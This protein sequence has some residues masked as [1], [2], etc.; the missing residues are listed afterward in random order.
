MFDPTQ[1]TGLIEPVLRNLNLSGDY[2]S[3]IMVAAGLMLSGI[4]APLIFS[5]LRLAISISVETIRVPIRWTRGISNELAIAIYRHG[6]LFSRQLARPLALALLVGVGYLVVAASF[7]GKASS[8][9]AKQTATTAATCSGEIV[10]L[11]C[12]RPR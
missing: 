7:G 3:Y 2:S 6:P 8:Q 9:A 1:L 10:D 4:F 12:P 11:S 5:L